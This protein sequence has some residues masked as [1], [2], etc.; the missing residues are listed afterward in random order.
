MRASSFSVPETLTVAFD[1]RRTDRAQLPGAALAEV[2][3]HSLKRSAALRQFTSTA[4]SVA[5]ASLPSASIVT[6]CSRTESVMRATSA[7]M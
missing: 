7:L 5:S 1:G 2:G 4:R 3:D 6:P